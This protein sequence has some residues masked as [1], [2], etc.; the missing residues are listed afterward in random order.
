MKKNVNLNVNLMRMYSIKDKL[1]NFYFPHS[2]PNDDLAKRDFMLATKDSS[3]LIGQ[4]TSDFA[5][6]YV[7]DFNCGDGSFVP[8]AKPFMLIDGLSVGKE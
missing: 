1:N 7:G 8:A 2:Y 4:C 5:L 6:Y 3:T